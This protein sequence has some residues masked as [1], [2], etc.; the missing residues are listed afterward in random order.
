MIIISLGKR[1]VNI[2]TTQHSKSQTSRD[3]DQ[4]CNADAANTIARCPTRQIIHQQ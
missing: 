2:K 1:L 4:D 3:C